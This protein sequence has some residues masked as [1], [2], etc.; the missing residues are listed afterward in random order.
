MSRVSIERRMERV[1]DAVLPPNS[2]AWRIDRLP[3]ELKQLHQLWR[4]HCAAINSQN[5]K[6]G[7][8]RYE[9]LLAG[10]DVTPQMPI[11]VHRALWPDDEGRAQITANMSVADAALMYEQM[12]EQGKSND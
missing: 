9:Q 12:L 6:Q 7:G 11:A 3:A 5:E 8:N 2:L 1:R 10:H 4:E